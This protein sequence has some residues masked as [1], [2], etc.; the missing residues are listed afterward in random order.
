[1]ANGDISAVTPLA[2]QTEAHENELKQEHLTCTER[3]NRS[4]K[5]ADGRVAPVTARLEKKTSDQQKP[6]RTNLTP[7]GLL[8]EGDCTNK[9]AQCV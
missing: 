1:M 3:T 6:S 2:E 9:L 5:S 7:T 8:M 4:S